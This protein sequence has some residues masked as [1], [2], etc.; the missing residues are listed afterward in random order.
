MKIVSLPTLMAVVLFWAYP[1]GAQ[2]IYYDRGSFLG[3][4]RV[5]ATGGIDFDSIANGTDLNNQTVQGITFSAPGSSPLLVMPGSSGVRFGLSPSSGLYVLSPGGPDQNLEEDDLMLVFA[6]PVQAFGLDVV[7]DVPDGAS[8]V[9]ASFYDELG[10][11]LGQDGFIPAPS[12]APG[13]QFVGMVANGAVIKQV[14]FDEFDPTANDDHVAYDS[15]VFSPAVIP[16]PGTMG[17]VVL[18]VVVL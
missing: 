17:V 2:T 10:N 8:Y 1:G 6:N 3:D 12:G 13:Y 16:E 18:G 4:G 7:L 15:L 14:V 5:G 9:S 11:L